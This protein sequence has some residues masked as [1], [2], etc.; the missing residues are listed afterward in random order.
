MVRTAAQAIDSERPALTRVRGGISPIDRISS[1]PSIATARST[2]LD[3]PSRRFYMGLLRE[4]GTPK[5]AARTFPAFTPAFGI[6][7][8]LHFEETGSTTPSDGCENSAS[9]ISGPD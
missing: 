6:C 1:A 8:W 3:F 4:D 7:Q 5:I 2:H 9:D